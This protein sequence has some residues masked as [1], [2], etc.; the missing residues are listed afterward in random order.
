[1]RILEPW[2]LDQEVAVLERGRPDAIRA[3]EISVLVTGRKQ[4]QL[5]ALA[6]RKFRGALGKSVP[7]NIIMPPHG[8]CSDH[9]HYTSD[10]KEYEDH[11]GTLYP[12]IDTDKVKGLNEKKEGSAKNVIKPWDDREDD[13]KVVQSAEDGELI[14][15]IPFT[16]QVKLKS[17]TVIG[18][19]ER[20]T[21]RHVKLWKNRD[22]IDFDNAED[23]SCDQEFDLSYDKD[24]SVQYLVK[25]S[26][27]QN[28]SSLTMFFSGISPDNEDDEDGKTIQINYIG[29][30]GE[31]TKNKHG[32]V[33]AVYEARALESEQKKLA[34]LNISKSV[35]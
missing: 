25:N 30:R 28:T 4:K 6:M 20:I 29:L 19:N 14:I 35:K 24:G 22:D 17:F 11:G 1:M 10:G 2:G 3:R 5:V 8:G 34:D 26:K 12:Q 9:V 7:Q 31:G 27:F 21:P 23:V 33:V 16:V 32:I 18:G 13:S 15:H